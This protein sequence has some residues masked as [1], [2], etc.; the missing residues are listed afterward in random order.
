MQYQCPL[1]VKRKPPIEHHHTQKD[2]IR[3][4]TSPNHVACVQCP[5]KLYPSTPTIKNRKPFRSSRL[6][7]QA[8]ANDCCRPINAQSMPYPAKRCFVY[9]PISTL[10]LS[11]SSTG[12][13]CPCAGGAADSDSLRVNCASCPVI[14][15]PSARSTFAP[16]AMVLIS[17][18]FCS[19]S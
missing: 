19:L 18:T 10:L 9:E 13:C 12:S 17:S 6:G 14:L 1:P 5:R 7:G 3:T 4:C 15:L 16:R 8:H 2:Q 11:G